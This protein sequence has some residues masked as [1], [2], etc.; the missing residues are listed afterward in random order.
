MSYIVGLIKE[1]LPDT[2]ISPVSHNSVEELYE[3]LI[4]F[5]NK[6]D[7]KLSI[8]L[9]MEILKPV[10]EA[11][12]PIIINIAGYPLSAMFG[13]RNVIM[14]ATNRFLYIVGLDLLDKE[15]IQKIADSI[16]NNVK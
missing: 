15:G 13:D 6:D 10:I 14:E 5:F 9:T 4:K 8:P 2:L 16:A 7:Y 11:N 12:Q 3:W 1:D